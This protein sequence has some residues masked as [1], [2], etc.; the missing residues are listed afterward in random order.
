MSLRI[1]TGPQGAWGWTRVRA[2]ENEE[3]SDHDF[4]SWSATGVCNPPTDGTV[5]NGGVGGAGARV[6][7]DNTIAKYY[8]I[9]K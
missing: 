1:K 8:C 6:A 5:A 9:V 3:C 2:R 7:H 4:S